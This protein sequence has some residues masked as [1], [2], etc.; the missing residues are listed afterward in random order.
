MPIAR[1]IGLKIDKARSACEDVF[2]TGHG[3]FPECGSL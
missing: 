1:R 3:H 2:V